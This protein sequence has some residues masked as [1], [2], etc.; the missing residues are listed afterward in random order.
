MSKCGK[1]LKIIESILWL[2]GDS[3]Y[4]CNFEHVLKLY[5]HIQLY[6]YMYTYK[7]IYMDMIFIFYFSF[8]FHSGKLNYSQMYNETRLSVRENLPVWVNGD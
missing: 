6:T 7:S 2:C 4:L 1:V 3:F 5:M 8:N